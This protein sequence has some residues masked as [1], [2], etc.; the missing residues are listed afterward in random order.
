MNS[1][2][3]Q[4]LDRLMRVVPA[5]LAGSV[6]LMMVARGTSMF[7]QGELG[8]FIAYAVEM[9]AGS[10][11]LAILVFATP[12]N[13]EGLEQRRLAAVEAEAERRRVQRLLQM[14]DMLQSANGYADAN[15]VLRATVETLLAGFCG[16]LY[17]F[18]NSRDRLELSTSWNWPE[19]ERLLK[20]LSP[21]LCWA[22]KRGKAHIN[23]NGPG[24]LRCEHHAS[25]LTVL[26]VPM[27]AHGEIQGMLKVA[28]GA[29][30][31]TARLAEIRPLAEA[32][33]DAMSL[34]VSNIALREKLRTQALRDP[35]T[36]LYNRRYMEDALERYASLAERSGTPLSAIMIDLDHF[37]KLNDEHGH[38]MGDAVLRAVAGAIIGALRPSDVACRYGGEELVVILPECDHADAM[39]IGEMLRT[40]IEA[41]SAIHDARIS[42]SF[43]VAS[44]P[45]TTRTAG[46]LL[47]MADA[48]LYQAKENGRNQ[49]AS[50]HRKDPPPI[51]IAAE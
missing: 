18:N 41:L 40:R 6:V 13:N 16:A 25:G 30:D 51:A 24:M 27:M 37:K 21:S 5:A 45:E 8:Q 22:L 9:L 23:G 15:A 20:T 2:S 49:V 47:T 31:A 26:E 34:A 38:A 36:G 43:G 1:K 48:A 19:D 14:T 42:A 29:E 28:T 11:A 39:H 44:I 33:A 10:I 12:R 4:A 50:A 17:I 7:V 35:L 46:D 32:V 3:S